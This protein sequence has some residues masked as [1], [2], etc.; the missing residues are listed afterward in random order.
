MGHLTL[1]AGVASSQ[2]FGEDINALLRRA[3]EFLYVAKRSGRNAVVSVQNKYQ[4][5]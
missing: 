2:Y 5:N 4:F 1:S 3:D